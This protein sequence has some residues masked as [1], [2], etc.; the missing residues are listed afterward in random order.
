MQKLVFT[1]AVLDEHCHVSKETVTIQFWTMGEVVLT[2]SMARRR[3]LLARRDKPMN[4][5]KWFVL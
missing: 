4:P 3:A 2:G 5:W 1:T